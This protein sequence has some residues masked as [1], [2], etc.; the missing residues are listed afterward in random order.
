MFVWSRGREVAAKKGH[1]KNPSQVVAQPDEEIEMEWIDPNRFDL[2]FR[3]LPQSSTSDKNQ[4]KTAL[5]GL[6]P[7]NHKTL[8]SVEPD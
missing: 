6:K 2:L 4:R 5:S 8:F 7:I 1:V 3:P